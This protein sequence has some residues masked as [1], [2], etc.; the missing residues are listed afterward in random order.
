MNRTH[1]L[2]ELLCAGRA[3][4]AWLANAL[5]CG[6]RTVYREVARLRAMGWSVAAAPGPR[7]GFWLAP[8]SRPAPARL[9]AEAAREIA[10]ALTVLDRLQG[11]ASPSG[12]GAL[13]AVLAAL[14]H[15]DRTDVEALLAGLEV[16]GA[17]PPGRRSGPGDRSTLAPSS[18]FD[19][20][21]VAIAR[22]QEILC[23]TPGGAERFAPTGLVLRSGLW[24]ATGTG[25]RS[26]GHSV[27]HSA[28][29]LALVDLRH[30]R[31]RP[32][33]VDRGWRSRP[34]RVTR[35]DPDRGID[36]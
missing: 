26:P 24:L 30:V 16:A 35:A 27:V 13:H 7:G 3:T 6:L 28:M 33:P 34:P 17:H 10:I 5:R 23:A 14:P 1:R 2:L 18:T 31:V 19:A 22:K 36:R 8:G 20:L 25:L 32:R 29:P 4:A 21:Q 15:R 11:E 9:P 12:Q